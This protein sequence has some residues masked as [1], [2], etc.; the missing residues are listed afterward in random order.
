MPLILEL[1]YSSPFQII[2]LQMS[3]WSRDVRGGND[4]IVTKITFLPNAGKENKEEALT[5]V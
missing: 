3:P 5:L 4:Y 1:V 2:S